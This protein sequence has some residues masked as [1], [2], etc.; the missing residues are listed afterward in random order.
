MSWL[1]KMPWWLLVG[2]CL[3]L[4]LAPFDPPHLWEK[5]GLLVR[6]DLVR[7][8]DV[9]DLLLHGSPWVLL[10]MKVAAHTGN[11]Q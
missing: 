4:G 2:L 9:F 5:L 7:P 10:G 1:R 11:H 8:V 6:G 3:T